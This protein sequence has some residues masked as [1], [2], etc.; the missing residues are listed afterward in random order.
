MKMSELC[1]KTL[2]EMLI[3]NIPLVWQLRDKISGRVVHSVYAD[4]YVEGCGVVSK[5]TT[6]Q[7]TNDSAQPQELDLELVDQG[8]AQYMTDCVEF[9]PRVVQAGGAATVTFSTPCITFGD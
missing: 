2:L 1:K 8:G 4:L 5:A 7:Y 9:M 6:L 3:G